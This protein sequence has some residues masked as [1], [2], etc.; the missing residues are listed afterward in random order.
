[1]KLA[2]P[3]YFT[4]NE[5]LKQ[6]SKIKIPGLASSELRIIKK[7]L[8]INLRSFKI[9]QK[10]FHENKELQILLNESR[11]CA[12][13]QKQKIEYVQREN[14][15]LKKTEIHLKKRLESFLLRVNRASKSFIAGFKDG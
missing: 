14:E 10:L 12:K 8:Q 3:S 13:K 1:M 5:K 9:M 4:K 11:D 7:L 2:K 15:T 6:V